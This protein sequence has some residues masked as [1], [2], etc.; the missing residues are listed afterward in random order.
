MSHFTDADGR[1]WLVQF[2]TI[3]AR[4]CKDELDVDLLDVGNE[5]LFESLTND[6]CLIVDV[7]HVCCREQ[8]DERG[9]DPVGFA[10]AL[11]GDVLDAAVE[12]FLQAYVSFFRRHRRAVLE[13]ALTKT[14][15][16]L[17]RNTEQAIRLINSDK[18]DQLLTAKLQEMETYFDRQLA[19]ACGPSSP[20]GPPSPASPPETASPS[21]N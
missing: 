16:F 17:Q 10:R 15:T 3:E 13:A 5:R 2:S 7:L 20:D 8:C 18:M 4:R 21:A 11:R 6:E 9:V 1:E 14:T 12:A 19:K